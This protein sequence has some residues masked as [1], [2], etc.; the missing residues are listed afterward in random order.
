M[1]HSPILFSI[2][3]PTY[4]RAHLISATIESILT[5][6]YKNFEVVIVDD[7]STDNTE[8]VVQKFLSDQVHYYK[9]N[10]AERAAARN[11]GTL[12]AKGEYI[13][14]FDS[15]DI[16]FFNHLQIAV[17]LVSKFEHPE[18][19]AQGFQYQDMGGF[20]FYK[21]FYPEDINKEL[22]RGNPFAID[23]VFVRRDIALANL[24]NEDRELSSSEDFE[25]WLRL[26]AKYKIPTSQDVT[27]AFIYHLQR[28][29][30]A[31]K[32]PNQL[33]TRYLK[34]IEYTTSNRNVATLLGKNRNIF[35]MKNYLLLSVDLVNNN[36]L[37][38][39]HKYFKKALLSSP[40]IIF[41][42]GFYAYIKHYIRHTFSGTQIPQATPTLKES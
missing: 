30:I 3:V 28:S 34:F 35:E 7:G 39:G 10:N 6:G 16:M 13:N 29:I 17:N 26:G 4:N 33:I 14:W 5:Q 24:F 42:R 11:F 32:N 18:V 22:Y 23:T 20:V 15:D 40:K 19:F 21:S 25:L 9:K 36:Y 1:P 31:M 38:L 8:E 37:E 2:I 41:E 12:K 27:A